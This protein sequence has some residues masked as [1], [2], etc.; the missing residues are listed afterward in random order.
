MAGLVAVRFVNGSMRWETRPRGVRRL[1]SRSESLQ[2]WRCTASIL[3]GNG[4]GTFQA[5]VTYDSCYWAEAVAVVD[6]N[7]DGKSDLVVACDCT[8]LGG[9]CPT[10]LV[11]VLLGNGDGT[12]QTATFY[13]TGAGNIL[14]VAVEDVN[15]DS[16]PDVLA[17]NAC[18]AFVCSGEEGVVAV[19]L[20]AAEA[21]ASCFGF[22]SVPETHLQH[23]QI[24][25]AE[26]GYNCSQAM[27]PVED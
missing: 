22:R 8:A 18:A 4:D 16:K 9:N 7:G 15:G 25:L 23:Q 12:F 26:Q 19:L 13:G 27:R 2:R 10:S 1:P 11:G 17:A 20:I 24:S 14:S 21:G 6:V 3:L 5:A